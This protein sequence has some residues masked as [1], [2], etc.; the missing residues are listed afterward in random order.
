MIFDAHVILAPFQIACVNGVRYTLF[1]FVFLRS[2][3][4][5]GIFQRVSRGEPCERLA[6]AVVLDDRRVCPPITFSCLFVVV[7]FFNLDPAIIPTA[8]PGHAP[9]TQSKC[10]CTCR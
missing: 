2:V 3:V 8:I 10:W 6:S 7:F 1:H 9:V 4:Y 5:P